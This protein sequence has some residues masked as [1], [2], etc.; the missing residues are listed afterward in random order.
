MTGTIHYF[1]TARHSYT[2]GYYAAFYAGPVGSALRIIPYE[3]MERMASF[4][5]G[6]FV[7]TDFDR[8]SGAELERLGP[9]VAAI[10]TN[11]GRILNHPAR[12]IGRYALL[13]MLHDRGVNAFNVYKLDEWEQVDR[14]PVFIR[15]EAGHDKPLTE[16]VEERGALQRAVEKLKQSGADT[17]DLMIAEFGNAPDA[18][19]KYR[20]YAAFKVGDHIYAQHCFASPGWWVKFT[21]AERGP[22]RTAEHDRYVKENPHRE[23]LEPIFAMANID[24]G[25]A[26]YCVVDGRVQIFEINTNPTVI[27]TPPGGEFD[28]TPYARLHDRALEGLLGMPSAGTAIP[29]PLLRTDKPPLDPL[30]MTDEIRRSYRYLE[31]QRKARAGSG[32]GQAPRAPGDDR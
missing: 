28:M 5:P 32:N 24:Y 8:L 9:L 20:K 22:E 3:A 11:G 23:G 4:E 12:A 30:R 2:I 16:P 17:G 19:G 13:R 26:D 21:T 10:E 27:Q 7:F 25:R 29:N 15:A 6:S 14:F 18:D 1:C 31:A